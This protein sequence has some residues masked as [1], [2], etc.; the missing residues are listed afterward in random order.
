MKVPFMERWAEHGAAGGRVQ[1][2][3]A[4]DSGEP[5]L[6]LGCRLLGTGQGAVSRNRN[7]ENILW[8]QSCMNKSCG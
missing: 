4:S 2:A 5:F 1:D 6:S 3:G 8:K 7:T